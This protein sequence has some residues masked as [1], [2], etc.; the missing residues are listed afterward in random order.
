MFITRHRACSDSVEISDFNFNNEFSK[1]LIFWF[2]FITRH[3]ACS[4]SVEISD[5]NI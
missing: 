5:F 3:R 4:D 1:K 2:M